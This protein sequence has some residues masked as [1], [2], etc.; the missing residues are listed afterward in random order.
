MENGGMK[1]FFFFL[2]SHGKQHGERKGNWINPLTA[3]RIA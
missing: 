2:K 3:H 1:D